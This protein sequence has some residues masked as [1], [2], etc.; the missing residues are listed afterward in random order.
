MPSEA[1]FIANAGLPVAPNRADPSTGTSVKIP[2]ARRK[3]SQQ[4]R[5]IDQSLGQQV[6][7]LAFALQDAKH[8]EQARAQQLAALPVG[9][10]LERRIIDGE[11]KGLEADL[12]LARAG[13]DRKSVV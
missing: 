10:R 1:I 9:E 8:P 2:A 4:R 3:P 7:H 11:S 6:H 13:G 5:V 12:D